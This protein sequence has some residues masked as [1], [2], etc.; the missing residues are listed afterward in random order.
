MS[1]ALSA[2][3]QLLLLALEVYRNHANKP[4]EWTPT[5]ADWAALKSEVQAAT[6]EQLHADAAARRQPG[7]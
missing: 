1:P 2:T 7:S 4:P 5:A 3:A 6:I